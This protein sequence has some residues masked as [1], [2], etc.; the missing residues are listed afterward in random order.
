VP[1][2][3]RNGHPIPVHNLRPNEANWSP[4]SVIFLDTESAWETAGTDEVHRLR[5]W[6]ACHVD[7]RNVRKTTGPVCW[8]WGRTAPDFAQWLSTRTRG[9]QSVWV[10]AHNLNFDLVT[11]GLADEMAALDWEITDFA[12]T[13]KTPWLRLRRGT[14]VVTVTDSWSWLP[15]SLESVATMMGDGK[16]RLPANADSM[17]DWWVRCAKDVDLTAR[18]VLTLMDWWDREQLGRWTISGAGS[19]W[20]AMRHRE[21]GV[22]HTIDPEPALVAQDRLAVR[23]GRKDAAVVRSATG[24]P[25]VELDLVAAYPTVARELP[26]PIKREFTFDHLPVNSGLIGNRFHGVIADC[27]ISTDRPRYPVHHQGVTWYPVGTFH[28]VLA[29]PELAWA[30]ANGDLMRVGAGQGHRLGLALRPWATWVLD[31]SEGGSVDVPAVA[32]LACKA[33]GRSVLGKFAARSHTRDQL[34]GAAPAGWSVTDMWDARVGRKG[35]EVTM[36]GR[37][38]LVTMDADTENCYP[39]VLAWVESEVRARLGRVLEALDG[40]WWTCDTDGLLVDMTNPLAW[41]GLGIVRVRDQ[42]RDAWG[43]A[44]ALCNQL[45]PEVAPLVLRPKKVF[46]SLAVLGPQHLVAGSER[47]LSGVRADAVEVQPGQFMA[48]DWPGLKWQMSHSVPGQYRRPLRTSTFTAPTVHRWVLADG[49]T[50]PVEMALTDS[51]ANQL[52]PFGG[53]WSCSHGVELAPAQYRLLERLVC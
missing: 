51:G 13:S 15:A 21:S 45:A 12:V 31:P 47:R 10:Y 39:A 46:D 5:C 33:W 50:A 4:P 3:G 27:V 35:A 34:E 38:W 29:G 18:A 44:Q 25:W 2:I 30:R 43:L 28:T 53:S 40:A 52:L 17:D 24:G 16:A 6:V 32:R 48:R 36:A 11:T 23:G 7:R 9:R 49:C 22:R 19:G 41:A 42:T 20:N 14:K 8:D 26:C 37:S 1:A